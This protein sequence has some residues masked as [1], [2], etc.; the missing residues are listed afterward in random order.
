MAATPGDFQVVA[1][2]VTSSAYKYLNEVLF[3]ALEG[4]NSEEIRLN[5]DLKPLVDALHHVLAGGK[6]KGDLIEQPGD[7]TQVGNLDQGLQDSINET[8]A[9]RGQLGRRF[10]RDAMT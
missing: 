2:N 1:V 8:N 6:L 5:P 3:V 9:L 7:P 10:G 4:A